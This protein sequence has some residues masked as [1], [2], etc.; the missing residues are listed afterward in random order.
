[1]KT[2]YFFACIFAAVLII[3][4]AILQFPSPLS[5][6]DQED[7]IW[8]LDWD[9]EIHRSYLSLPEDTY[10]TGTW[11]SHQ[12]WVDD[13]TQIISRVKKEPCKLTKEECIQLLYKAQ[14]THAG[15]TATDYSTVNWNAR[16]FEAYTKIITYMKSQ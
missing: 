1:M 2:T 10:G 11:A 5:E 12:Q 15:D 16:W 8:W 6:F 4:I 14:S 3:V 13:F 9:R 7:C